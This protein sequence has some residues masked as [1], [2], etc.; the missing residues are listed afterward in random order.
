MGARSGRYRNL[1]RQGEEYKIEKQMSRRGFLGTAGKTAVLSRARSFAKLSP[2][3]GL[4]PG[5]P[6]ADKPA[7]RIVD[8]HVHFDEKKP[9]FLDDLL[10]LADR[11]NLTA[12]LLTPF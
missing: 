1:R 5:E 3:A 11:A 2:F 7:G 10:K 8:M 9:G 4:V 6:T 12:C